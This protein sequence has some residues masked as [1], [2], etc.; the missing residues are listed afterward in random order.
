MTYAE[1]AAAAA[2]YAGLDRTR[3][4]QLCIADRDAAWAVARAAATGPLWAQASV[5][6][7]RHHNVGGGHIVRVV[8]AEDRQI[9]ILGP[10]G[11]SVACCP[12]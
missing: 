7:L 4:A 12:E 11:L 8:R 2:F 3:Q 9:A 6:T 5:V 10:G 1:E